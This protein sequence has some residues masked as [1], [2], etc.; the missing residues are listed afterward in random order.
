MALVSRRRLSIGTILLGSRANSSL[1]HRSVSTRTHYDVLR[2]SRNA[3][4]GDIRAAFVALS[5]K[6]HPDVSKASNANKHFSDINEA[7]R[8]LINPSKRYQYDLLLHSSEGNTRGQHLGGHYP[9]GG[10]YEYTRNYEYH[11]LS[12]E[13]WNKIYHQ[14]MHRP[15]HSKVIRWL[16]VMMVVG[17]AVHT[18]RINSAHR[19]F[20]EQ[21]NR[22]TKKNLAIYED[23]RERARNST[24]E[25]QLG[26][27]SKI[28][29]ENAR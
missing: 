22:E 16:I 2:L 18:I 23:V 1:S 19:Q 17:T 28:H 14:S 4:K 3:S 5:K 12:A 29:R 20:Q 27:L 7:Y 25:Q 11:T 15:D 26:R 9:G 24:V 8:V 6:H 13:E 21:N 10:M